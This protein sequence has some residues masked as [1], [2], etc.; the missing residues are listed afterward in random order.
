ML[1]RIILILPKNNK[2]NLQ[3]RINAFALLGEYLRL[4]KDSK[5]IEGFDKKNEQFRKLEETANSAYLH[6]GWFI[7]EN[8]WNM[9]FAIGESL[10]KNNLD[11]WVSKYNLV[12]DSEPKTVAV[13]MA[14]NIPAVGFHDFMSVLISGNRVLAKLSSDDNKLIPAIADLLISIEPEFKDLIEFTEGRLHSF[15]AV[16]ATGSGNTGRYFDYYF[17]KY[18]HIIRRNRNGAAVLTNKETEE[19]FEQLAAD[20]FMYFGLGCRSISKLFVPL[21][22]DFTPMLDVLSQKKKVVDHHKYFNNYEY[23][24]AIYLVNSRPHLDA[25]NLLLVEDNS[26]TSPVSVL[27]YEYYESIDSLNHKLLL[28]SNSIQCIVS[29]QKEV[30]NSIPLG[31]SQ[32]PQLWDYADG[33]DTMEFLISIK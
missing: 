3:Q 8:V 15:D 4:F 7:T 9:L 25:G 30:A 22:Y 12:D 20:V 2:V 29:S 32:S 14:G 6:N 27:H 24:K 18:Q 23:N 1:F 26:Y 10:G 16:I 11:K 17:G 19:D 21:D 31:T 28:E 33:V 13:V 5:S